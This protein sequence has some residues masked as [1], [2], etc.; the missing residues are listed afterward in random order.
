MSEHSKALIKEMS[1]TICRIRVRPFVEI[2]KPGKPAR[3]KTITGKGEVMTQY[4][5]ATHHP[6]DYDP[7]IEDEA[8]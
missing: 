4:L 6:E 8:K 3:P 5:V 1:W 7:S 2:V